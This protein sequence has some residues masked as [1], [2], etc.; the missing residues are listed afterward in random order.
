MWARYAKLR[1]QLYPYLAA[2]ESRVRPHRHAADAAPGAGL[3]AGRPRATAR[4]DEYLLGRNLLVAP[5]VRPDERERAL[6]LPPGRWIDWWRSIS[7]DQRGA[8]ALGAP[9][10]ARAAARDVTLPAPLDE[11]PLLVREGAVLP[12]L[13]P[14]VE[15]LADYGEGTAVRLRDREDRLRL[16]AWPRGRTTASLGV[17]GVGERVLSNET[18]EGWVLE[19]RGLER[20]TYEIQAALGSLRGGGFRPCAVSNDA[21]GPTPVEE[22][23]YD[24]ATGVLAMR[25]DAR[26][27][28]VVVRR[29]C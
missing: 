5:V 24:E 29:S 8:P 7:L 22:W 19:I 2:A 9:R 6:Y 25:L 26:N 17:A 20:R 1:T 15:T 14:S 27:A 12:L 13:D 18:G 3:S 21:R 11:L 16:L 10:T 4:E 28:R 23:S